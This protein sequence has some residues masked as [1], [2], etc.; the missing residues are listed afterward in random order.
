MTGSTAKIE[1]IVKKY[2]DIETFI[3]ANLSQ[4]DQE[5]AGNIGESAGVEVVELN[6]KTIGKL[7]LTYGYKEDDYI[8]TISPELI[9]KNLVGTQKTQKTPVGKFKI[10]PEQI[11]K[12]MAIMMN[13]VI[14]TTLTVNLFPPGP[15][16]EIQEYAAKIIDAKNAWQLS[17]D[18][19]E[20]MALS[21]GEELAKHI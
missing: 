10:A 11:L 5:F 12:A 6:E 20:K 18:A 3:D 14:P 21:V 4:E 2:G 9:E 19:L 13:K 7:H 16:W 1:E 17:D 15:D 8:V